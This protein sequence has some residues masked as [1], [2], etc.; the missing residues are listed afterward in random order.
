MQEFEREIM[1]KV[2]AKNI[3]FGPFDKPTGHVQLEEEK[4][5][6]KIEVLENIYK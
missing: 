5:S 3:V 2:G 6:F 1:D 4:V